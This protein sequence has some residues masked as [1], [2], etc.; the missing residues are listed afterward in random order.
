MQ[1]AELF[2]LPS[3]LSPSVRS[4]LPPLGPDLV[5]E[6]HEAVVDH[7]GDGHVQAHSAHA[8]QRSLVEGACTLLLHDPSEQ[9]E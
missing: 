5:E 1:N 3:I 6:V 7:E 9:S 8:R 4:K 2:I